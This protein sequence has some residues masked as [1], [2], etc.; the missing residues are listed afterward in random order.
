M[1]TSSYEV[2]GPPMAQI[3]LWIPTFASSLSQYPGYEMRVPSGRPRRPFVTD[4]TGMEGSRFLRISSRNH[5]T[6][7]DDTPPMMKSAPFMAS[8]QS[9]K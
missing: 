7:K 5:S 2:Q 6:P 3:S 9:L 8:F 1:K 4:N